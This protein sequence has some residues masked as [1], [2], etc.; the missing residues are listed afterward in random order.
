MSLQ[1]QFT[2]ISK[3]SILVKTHAER[4]E[5][6]ADNH[7][8]DFANWLNNHVLNL[9]GK[10]NKFNGNLKATELILIYKSEKGL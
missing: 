2:H 1:K 6:L 10:H 7:A 4:C 3:T 9:S 8:V 5:K